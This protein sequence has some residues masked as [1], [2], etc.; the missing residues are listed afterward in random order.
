MDQQTPAL[1]K[2]SW[3]APK[4]QPSPAALKGAGPQKASFLPHGCLATKGEHVLFPARAAQK[5]RALNKVFKDKT[6]Q[7]AGAY[8]SSSTS[9]EI[10]EMLVPQYGVQRSK[11]ASHVGQPQK[12]P[13]GF[14]LSGTGA[15]H[16]AALAGAAAPPG[17]KPGPSSPCPGSWWQFWVCPEVGPECRSCTHAAIPLK[18]GT[19]EVSKP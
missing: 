15:H 13:K 10:L 2:Q 17:C 16:I 14:Q 11:M 18:H 5:D 19:E 1:G 4:P 9:G 6:S 8:S 12:S 7:D 3:T